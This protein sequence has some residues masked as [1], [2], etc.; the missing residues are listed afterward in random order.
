LVW[1]RVLSD[2]EIFALSGNPWAV[3]EKERFW[4]PPITVGTARPS[5]DLSR[6]GWTGY[7]DNNNLYTNIDE[8]VQDP[9]DWITSPL[10]DGTQAGYTFTL[11]STQAAGSVTFNFG[12]QVKSGDP[13]ATGQL[14]LVL[15]DAAQSVVGTGAWKT[16]ATQNWA[17]YT[18]TITLSGTAV[19]GRLEV[20]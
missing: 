13:T 11:S 14:R 2:S 15:L 7:T 12:A 3:F 10:L 9:A 18:D 16:I 5:S 17:N 19:Y 6:G 20:Q 4:V 1:N 8:P